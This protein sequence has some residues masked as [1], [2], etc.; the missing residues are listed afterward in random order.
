[1]ST[2]QIKY[3]QRRSHVITCDL[4]TGKSEEV[5]IDLPRQRAFHPEHTVI[6]KRRVASHIWVKFVTN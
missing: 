5:Q 4:D 1:M 6:T 2:I 3:D